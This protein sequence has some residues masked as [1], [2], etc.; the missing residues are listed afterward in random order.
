VTR[1]DIAISKGKHRGWHF[2]GN[3]FGRA[4]I[5]I[6]IVRCASTV[7]DDE[8]YSGA[9]SG[10]S[11]TLRVIVGT[12]RNVSEHDSI[13][14]PDIDSQLECR[15]AGQDIDFRDR[16]RGFKAFFELEPHIIVYLCRVF[17][18]YKRDYRLRTDPTHGPVLLHVAIRPLIERPVTT[19]A[20]GSALRTRDS[21]TAHV[22]SHARLVRCRGELHNLVVHLEKGHAIARSKQVGC[23]Q[24]RTSPQEL[25]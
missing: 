12:R 6:L 7:S 16:Q 5:E 19:W 20:R 22:A 3:H 10:T 21:K 11:A 25:Q 15:R 18:C 9:P 2:P 23:D 4:I 8:P 24:E 1:Q 14:S 13:E 17:S